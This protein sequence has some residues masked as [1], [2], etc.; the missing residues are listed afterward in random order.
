MSL[1]YTG[2]AKGKAK[3]EGGLRGQAHVTRQRAVWGLSELSKL[4][5]RTSIPILKSKS[6]LY[7]RGRSGKLEEMKVLNRICVRVTGFKPARFREWARALQNE[8]RQGNR[9]KLVVSLLKASWGLGPNRTRWRRRGRACWRCPIY[10][11]TLKICRP[12]P[13]SELGCGCW[14]PAKSL[15][16]A[17]HCWVRR[18]I[19]GTDLGAD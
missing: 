12:F 16:R 10:N 17:G 4:L 2:K 13:G 19:P 6:G 3:T 9:F 11:R 5:P 14:M 18:A 7:F 15:V 1:C 8:A